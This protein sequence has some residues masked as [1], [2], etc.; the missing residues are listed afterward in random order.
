MPGFT[1]QAATSQVTRRSTVRFK[2]RAEL[3]DFLL[4]V[5][6]ATAHTLD[7]DQLLANVSEIIKR[8]IPSDVFAILLYNEKE[9]ALHIR[10]A[11]GHR[12]EII[13]NLSI[14]LG[15]GITGAAAARREAILVGDVRADERYLA[16]V[17]AVRTELAV[18]MLARN[19]LVGVIDVQS[20]AVNAYTEY[21]RAL[22]RLIAARVGSA[23][24]N[25][26]LFRRAERQNKTLKTLA[27]I[28]HEFSSILDLDEL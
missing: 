10:Y 19:K 25:A 17:D 11:V 23:I 6:A 21:E 8:V 9:Q 1:S 14:A 22:L 5:S 26:R 7:L 16:S 13:R 12:E 4:E 27:H 24:D 20:T 18:P 15:E 2:E 28:S 3:L